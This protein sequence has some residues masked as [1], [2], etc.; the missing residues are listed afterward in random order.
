M[1]GMTTSTAT[2]P[3]LYPY[4]LTDNVCGETIVQARGDAHAREL[5]RA[6]VM[7][8][9]WN[10]APT[11]STRW[12]DVVITD[13]HG[14]YEEIA[15]AVHPPEPAC[16]HEQGHEWRRP[17][18]VGCGLRYAQGGTVAL[19]VCP[20]CGWYRQETR[21]AQRPDTGAHGRD[22]TS[23]THFEP[24]EDSQ[25]WID[26]AKISVDAIVTEYESRD[27]ETCDWADYVLERLEEMY[28]DAEISVEYGPHSRQGCVVSSG[29]SRR[30]VEVEDFNRLC[31]EWFAD[32]CA[33]PDHP[34]WGTADGE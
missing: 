12:I 16:S 19:E 14:D 4:T 21:N 18:A 7:G 33:Q 23:I 6:W 32:L 27:G 28:P 9:D 10:L 15:V 25:A 17:E 2:V 22:F 30:D 34:A 29:I 24:D 31:N 1:S 11:D 3:A 20:H 8:G 5:A 13:E 26:G